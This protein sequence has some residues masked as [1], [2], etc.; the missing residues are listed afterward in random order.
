MGTYESRLRESINFFQTPITFLMDGSEQKIHSSAHMFH[1]TNF[2][3]TK[4]KQHSITILLI[5]SPKGRILFVSL[6][7]YG[8]VVDKEL[9]RHT[10]HLWAPKLT[11]NDWGMA[12]TGFNGQREK[13]GL[14]ILT[15]QHPNGHPM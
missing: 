3:S 10:M 2:F 1:E 5:I 6:C 15:P 8:S 4:K 9:L 12:D 13:R 7:Y 14:N 11:P